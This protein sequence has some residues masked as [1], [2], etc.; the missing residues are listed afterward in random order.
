MNLIQNE[1][2]YCF[3][4][5]KLTELFKLYI[6]PT[7]LPQDRK[8]VNKFGIRFYIYICSHLTR[9]SSFIDLKTGYPQRIILNLSDYLQ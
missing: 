6:K 4:Q 7:F 3:K 9:L 5:E 8:K 1:N 2:F